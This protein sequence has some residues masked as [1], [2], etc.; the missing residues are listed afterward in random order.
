MDFEQCPLLCPIQIY[1]LSKLSANDIQIT[2]FDIQKLDLSNTYGTV[3][4]IL[5]LVEI[6]PDST[7]IK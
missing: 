2:S 1:I 6:Q 4:S 7:N 3:D 5:S